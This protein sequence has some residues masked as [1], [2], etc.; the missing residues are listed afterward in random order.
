M[1]SS[2]ITEFDLD[3]N[4]DMAKESSLQEVKIAIENIPNSLPDDIAKEET[5]QEILG[6]VGS[7]SGKRCVASDSVLK[8]VVSAEQTSIS[9][10]VYVNKLSGSIRIT[11]SLKSSISDKYA[12]LVIYKNGSR[13]GN[14]LQGSTTSY[15]TQTQY[16]EVSDGDILTF[17]LSPNS[18]NTPYCNLLTICGDVS[19]LSSEPF[20]V[21]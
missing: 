9:Q 17:D 21:N 7:L 2:K 15:I 16:V 11:V 20:I 14:T 13:Y 12:N 8:T 4:L 5:S 1:S 18:T 6:K 3:A 10:T 19:E